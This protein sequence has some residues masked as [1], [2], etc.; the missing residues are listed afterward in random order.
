MLCLNVKYFVSLLFT[1]CQHNAVNLGFGFE[2]VIII[3]SL[4]VYGFDTTCVRFWTTD[5]LQRISI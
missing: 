4:F 1:G 2:E 3:K 5:C